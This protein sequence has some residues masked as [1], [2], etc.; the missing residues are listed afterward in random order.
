MG[1]QRRVNFLR[2]G[3]VATIALAVGVG[4]SMVPASAGVGLATSAELA[5]KTSD[6]R[7]IT[8][9]EWTTAADFATGA[10]AGV[11][12]T[13]DELQLGSAAGTTSYTDPF[14][15]GTAKSYDYAT[16]TS[17]STTV[18]FNATEAIASWN[19]T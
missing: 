1:A 14:G 6:V 13:G 8:Y 17:P 16:W 3:L 15:D 18:G 4:A 5:K 9:E 10:A 11:V 2:I 12:T 7:D 19:A